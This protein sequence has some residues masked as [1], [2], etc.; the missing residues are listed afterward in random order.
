MRH[1]PV[2]VQGYLEYLYICAFKCISVHGGSLYFQSIF[3][4][5]PRYRFQVNIWNESNIPWK[6]TTPSYGS[7][8]QWHQMLFNPRHSSLWS[9]LSHILSTICL[10]LPPFLV[11]SLQ[12]KGFFTGWQPPPDFPFGFPFLS[13]SVIAG[14]SKGR[15]WTQKSMFGIQALEFIWLCDKGQLRE[16][17]ITKLRITVG[18]P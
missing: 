4:Q 1:C 8:S 13:F 14:W 16:C 2:A 3:D 9:L 17:L 6:F 15:V 11:N 18:T 10:P 12:F 5:W 7:V